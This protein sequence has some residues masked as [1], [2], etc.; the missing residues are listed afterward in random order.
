[1]AVTWARFNAPPGGAMAE[2]QAVR[3]KE[4]TGK[5]K[6]VYVLKVTVCVISFGMIFPNIMHD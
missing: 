1:L 3:F 5:Q 2:A 4:M 6:F